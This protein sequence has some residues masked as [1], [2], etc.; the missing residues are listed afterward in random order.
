MRYP[1][2]GQG[3]RKRIDYTP[4]AINQED[5]FP[6]NKNATIKYVD[7]EKMVIDQSEINWVFLGIGAMMF[8]IVRPTEKE[9][10]H[11]GAVIY[12]AYLVKYTGLF[13]ALKA[14]VNSRKVFIFN[15][16]EG[17]LTY[18]ELVWL[19]SKT[20]PF[21]EACFIQNQVGPYGGEGLHLAIVR[22]D[23]IS[24]S[25]ICWDLPDKYFSLFVWYMDKNRPLPPGT[26]LDPYRER[27]YEQRKHRKFPKPLYSGRILTPDIG[28]EPDRYAKTR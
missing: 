20:I 1:K 10:I 19:T 25:V 15:R 23:G 2:A 17:T 13:L 18:P 16:K 11:Y 28:P 26:A 8:F 24:R 27:D 3:L 5:V 12:L 21:K 9:I 14:V 7:D 4:P 6:N 22:A